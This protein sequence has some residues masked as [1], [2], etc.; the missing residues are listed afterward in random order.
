MLV[1]CHAVM[2]APWSPWRPDDDVKTI[3]P[4]LVAFYDIRL[5]VDVNKRF[6]GSALPQPRRR[7]HGVLLQIGLQLL[8]E[9]L[10]LSQ[11]VGPRERRIRSFLQPRK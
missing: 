3:L 7:R 1:T 4:V 9:L 5:S 2:Q 10:F 6:Y 8:Q 11:H